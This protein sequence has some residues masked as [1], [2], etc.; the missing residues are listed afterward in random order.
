MSIKPITTHVTPFPLHCDEFDHPEQ[1]KRL[2]LRTGERNS[3][4]GVT[5][6]LLRFPNGERWQANADELLYALKAVTL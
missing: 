5:T 1:N 6:I 2:F 3:L 4:N